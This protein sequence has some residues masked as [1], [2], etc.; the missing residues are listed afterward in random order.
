MEGEVERGVVGAELADGVGGGKVEGGVGEGNDAL[1]GGWGGG[2]RGEG[3]GD[4][5]VLREERGVLRFV[6]EVFGCGL[7]VGEAEGGF[8]DLTCGE[9]EPDVGDYRVDE[10]EDGEA[11][12]AHVGVCGWGCDADAVDRDYQIAVRVC[13]DWDI[14]GFAQVAAQRVVAAEC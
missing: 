5:G 7:V 13:S 11:S 8:E 12:Y 2:G 4:G 10:S 1:L 14:E 9:R 6:D 3:E